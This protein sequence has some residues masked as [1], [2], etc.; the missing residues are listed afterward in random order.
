MSG[1]EE[2]ILYLWFFPSSMGGTIG[3]GSARKW[4]VAARASASSGTNVGGREG[5]STGDGS[6]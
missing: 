3:V 4:S 2:A 5:V 1:A 6:G